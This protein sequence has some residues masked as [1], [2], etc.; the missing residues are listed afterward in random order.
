MID[1]ITECNI[2]EIM[3]AANH[4]VKLFVQNIEFPATHKRA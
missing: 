3:F 2:V 4:D 1:H